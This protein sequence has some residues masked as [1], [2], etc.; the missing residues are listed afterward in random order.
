MTNISSCL[1]SMDG[2]MNQIVKEVKESENNA[3]FKER[4]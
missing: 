3:C 4:N 2:S 1:S